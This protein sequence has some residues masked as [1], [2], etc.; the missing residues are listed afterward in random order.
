MD[1]RFNLHCHSNHSDGQFTVTEWLEQGRVLADER[2]AITDNLPAFTIA[3]T[4]HDCIAG[5]EEIVKT[6]IKNPQKYQNLRIV[7]GAELGAVWKDESCQRV[8][9]E[10]ELI[11]Y[12]LNPFDKKITDF[13]S[14]HHFQRV[15]VAKEIVKKLSSR[16]PQAGLS[17][18][19][20]C[21]VQPLLFKNQG[22]G[23]YN[24]IYTYAVS[25][26]Q[27]ESQNSEIYDICRTFNN[28]FEVKEKFNPYQNTDDIFHLMRSSGFGFIGIAHPQKIN[29]AKFIKPEFEQQC[30]AENKNPAYELVYKWLNMLRSKGLKAM[31]INYQFNN[32]DLIRAQNMI[33]NKEIIDNNFPAY[34][35]LKLFVDY[36][37]KYGI[38]SA[39]GYD[40][41]GK[42]LRAR[43]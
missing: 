35:W 17:Y 38:L 16:F 31:D 40:S 14:V 33:L 10:Y 22:L 34:H 26:I 23:F 4:D 13:L 12:S 32:D 36:A 19:E 28:P 18:H 27:D 8:P 3:L 11:W 2:S 5:C 24:R 42:N 39:G 9:L 43:H 41:H 15:N 1:F 37:D 30:Y 7:L 29:T 25:K 20:A 6:L 21:Q